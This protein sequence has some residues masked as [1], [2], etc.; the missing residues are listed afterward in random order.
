MQIL[1]EYPALLAC[2]IFMIRVI[3]V[4]LGTLRTIMVFRGFRLLATGIAFFE[5]L[6]WILAV[7]QVLQNMGHWYLAVAYA[8]GFATGNYVGMWIDTKLALGSELVRAIS[9]NPAIRL[10]EHLRGNGFDVTE[11]PG[12]SDAA[13]VEVLLVV[14]RR[15]HIPDL[16]RLIHGRDPDA[17]CTLSDIRH[18]P[19]LPRNW[20]RTPVPAGGLRSTAKKK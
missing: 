12:R 17:V 15:K 18:P 4:S 14:E 1:H 6:L 9:S 8:G 3:D 10:A 13:D 5:V 11:L 16:L 7:S 2:A 19:A 20:R